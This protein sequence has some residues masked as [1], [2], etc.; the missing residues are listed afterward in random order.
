MTRN[1][2]EIETNRKVR[3]E[4]RINNE[5]KRSNITE[6]KI[7]REECLLWCNGIRDISAVGH[8]FNP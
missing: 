5:R 7:K 1:K 4:R 3:Q 8:G 2:V 6:L